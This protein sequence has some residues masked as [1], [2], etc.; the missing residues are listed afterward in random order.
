[1]SWALA[2]FLTFAVL[3]TFI[4]AFFI[5]VYIK[6]YDREERI[7]AEINKAQSKQLKYD[8]IYLPIEKEPSM[9][10]E[11]KKLKKALDQEPQI[12]ND[13]ETNKTKKNLN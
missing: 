9:A 11:V 2:F 10:K 8:L 13:T 4:F 5:F 1:M 3:F 7:V 12:L 6:E